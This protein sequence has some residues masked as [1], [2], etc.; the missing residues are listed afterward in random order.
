MMNV[1]QKNMEPVNSP[2]CAF[3][4]SWRKHNYFNPEWQVLAEYDGA[5][6]LQR[7]Y[8]YGNYIDEPLVMNDG[9]DD[10][11][12]AHDHLYSVVVLL[13]DS[14]NVVERYEY[15]A[16]GTATVFTDMT[17]WQDESPTTASK[18]AFGNPY[19]FTGRRLDMLD[20][21]NL[22][23]QYSRH[24]TYDTYT[25]RFYQHDPKGYVDGMNMYEYVK[26]NPS[27]YF[28][29]LGLCVPNT[30]YIIRAC[31]AIDKDLGY[32]L[33]GILGSISGQTFL[34]LLRYGEG[35]I[36][37]AEKVS[38]LLRNSLPTAKYVK[39]A[40]FRAEWTEHCSTVTAYCNCH[41]H[42]DS[43]S[44]MN[45]ITDESKHGEWIGSSDS[46]IIPG[47]GLLFDSFPNILVQVKNQFPA[48]YSKSV[49]TVSGRCPSSVEEIQTPW[50]L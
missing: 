9:T 4:S 8:V 1:E 2:S 21:G 41:G 18:S 47:W 20:N 48:D 5:G 46:F 15:D 6:A 29:P 37:A 45:E 26:S 11:Y 10:Y 7:Y 13:D 33:D 34:P 44:F 23:S 3:L 27:V 40:K 36:E 19:M 25:G 42:Y 39:L 49:R 32:D 12:Y 28:D 16:Y 24:R 14:G 30:C 43:S 17:D 31:W 38:A 35:A 22:L 50:W